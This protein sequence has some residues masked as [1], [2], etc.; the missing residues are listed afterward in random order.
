M[1]ALAQVKIKSMTKHPQSWSVTRRAGFHQLKNPKRI[2]LKSP[3]HEIT[4]Q[5]DHCE[6]KITL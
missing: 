6:K 2:I 4:E 3:S 1:T 5:Q